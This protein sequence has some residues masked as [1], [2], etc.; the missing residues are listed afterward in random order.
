[1]ALFERGYEL[2]RFVPAASAPGGHAEG[3]RAAAGE[4]S[5][6][7]ARAIVTSPAKVTRQWLFES[8]WGRTKPFHGASWPGT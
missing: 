6:Y 8:R 7:A 2:Q 3:C 1:M 5:F 4:N